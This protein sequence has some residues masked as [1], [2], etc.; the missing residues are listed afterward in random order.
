VQVLDEDEIQTLVKLRTEVPERSLDRLLE[1]AE[2]TGLVP[3]GKVSRSTLHRVL[4]AHGVSGRARGKATTTDL[5]RF[6][7]AAPNDLWQSD[8]LAGPWLPDPDKPGKHRR[9]WLYAFLD[10]HSRCLLAGR[11]AFKGSLPALELVFREAMRRHG[12][13]KRVYYDNGAVYRS[14]HM[15]QVVASLG[16][17]KLIFTQPYRPQG[18]GKI[19]AFNRL[20]RAA[21][22]SEVK[23]SAIT[24]LDGLNEAFRAWVDRYYNRR[25]H[26]ETG[27]EPLARWRA[28]AHAVQIPTEHALRE[29]FLWTA[30]RK[31]DKTG[32]FGLHGQRYQV[33]P[34][35]AGNKV[36]VRYDPERT[37]QVEIWL[38]GS[39]RE[40]VRPFEV[41]VHRRPAAPKPQE[42]D[43]GGASAP[44]LDWLG[45]LVEERRGQLATPDEA[46]DA[47]LQ[48]RVEQDE[49]VLARVE[50][51]VATETFDPGTVRDFLDRYGPYDPDAFGDMLDFVIEHMGVDSHLPTLL[52][53]VRCALG[54]G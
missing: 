11:F 27:Q 45:H 35:L 20:C 18:H 22:I 21:F 8:M 53:A 3:K 1:M 40:R 33:G 48:E 4:V 46:L 43:A 6:E 54:G 14:R 47:A 10:D 30:E 31:A 37:E 32:L 44:T 26:S 5:D 9:A 34:E 36:E 39:F 52:E 42:P 38:D 2:D 51:A 28:G 23:A 19:E 25:V 49:G 15:G 7:A 12:V 17:H 29:A 24:T 41:T 50:A 16:I 13:P